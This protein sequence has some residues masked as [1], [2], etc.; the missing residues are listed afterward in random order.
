MCGTCFDKNRGFSTRQRRGRRF[1]GEKA[2]KSSRERSSTDSPQ[3]TC[4]KQTASG[5][6]T[7]ETGAGLWITFRP[8]RE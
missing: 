5:P 1:L 2:P 7:P 8:A 6:E 3:K 4:E